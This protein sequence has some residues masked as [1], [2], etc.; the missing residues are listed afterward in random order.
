MKKLVLFMLIL[1]LISVAACSPENTPK[2]NTGDTDNNQVAQ[3]DGVGEEEAEVVPEYEYPELNMG[4]RDFR[5]LN[6]EPIWNFLTQIV[7]EEANGEVLN[8]AIYERNN[9]IQEKFNINMV[10]STAHIDNMQSRTRTSIMAGED[11]YDIIYCP[12]FNGAPIGSLIT[13]GLFYNFDNIPTVNLEA[14]YWKT[15]SIEASRL[16]NN[17]GIYFLQSDVHLMSLQGVWCVFFNETMMQNRGVEFPYQLAREGKWTLDKFLEYVKAGVDLNG[18]E[19]FNWNTS[20]NSVYGLSTFANGLGA[21]VTGTDEPFIKKDADNIPYLA[22]ENQRFFN[23]I[24]KLLEIT[25]VPGQFFEA[26]EDR[27]GSN[28]NYEK[29]FEL[30][31]AFMIVAEFKSADLF[32]SMEDSFGIVPMP[33]YDETQ[34]NYRHKIFNQCPVLVVPRTNSIPNETGIIMD[35]M[36]YKSNTEVTPVYYDVSLSFKGLRN[37]DSIE[38]MHIINNSISLELGITYDWTSQLDS[39]INTG[40]EKGKLEIASAIERRKNVIE[41]NIQKTMDAM[42][43][44]LMSE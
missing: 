19:S 34:E 31:R 42:E 38:M 3:T 18:D 33:K 40:L 4:G 28:K 22:I 37:D 13:Q 29:L 1:C 15:A 8:D 17:N 7:I 10:E 5:I 26:N 32:R 27:A 36:E 21:L 14:N 9:F 24:D 25:S 43:E 12:R 35:A 16:G 30:G 44:M 39:D 20:G 6:A 23:A 2:E 11:A 41:S